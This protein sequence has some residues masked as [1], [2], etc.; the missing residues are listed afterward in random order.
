MSVAAG[1]VER[2]GKAVSAAPYLGFGRR[3]G[4]RWTFGH[5]VPVVVA[6]LAFVFVVEGLRDRSAMVSVPVASHSIA[7]GSAVNSSD[8]RLVRAHRSDG[9]VVSGLLSSFALG[10]G[11]WV[12]KTTIAAGSPIS[13]SV[14]AR[15]RPAGSGLGSMSIPVPVDQADGGGI[16]AGDVVDVIAPSGSGGAAYVAQGLPVLGV[17]S[18]RSS[19][20]LASTGAYYIV[21]AVDRATAL[22]LTAAL[23][24]GG[25]SAGTPGGIEVVRTTGE[26]STPSAPLD[27]SAGSTDSA[28]GGGR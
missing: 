26:T 16:V 21:V 12:A 20:L 15:G 18:T 5:V 28:S 19:G 9:A 6:V 4:E 27:S 7:A 22:R 24:A 1:P 11:G 10:G 14:V 13:E 3:W 2:N 25:S 23:S 8:T 17:D